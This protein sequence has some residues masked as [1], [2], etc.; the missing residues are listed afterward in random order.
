MSLLSLDDETNMIIP[1]STDAPVYHFPFAT[2]GL[3]VVNVICFLISGMGSMEHVEQWASFSLQHGQGLHPVQWVT[4]NFLHAG[5]MHLAGNMIFFWGFGLVVEGKL[6]WWKMLVVYLGIGMT[7]CAIEQVLMLGADPMAALQPMIAAANEAM[8]EGN[9]PPDQVIEL[10]D[11]I[12]ELR[13]GTSLDRLPGSLGAS[14]IIY[15]MLAMSLVWAPKNEVNCLF[16]AGVRSFTFEI[17]IMTFALWYIG[18]EILMTTLQGFS[19]TTPLLHLMGAGV[20]FAAGVALLKAQ[21]VDCED[22]DLFAV[23][24]GH[25]G[26]FAR[27]SYGNRIERPG[28][29]K[30][31][32]LTERKKTPAKKAGPNLS[33]RKKALDQIAALIESGNFDEANDELYNLRIKDSEAVL[34]EEL[35]SRLAVGLA[36]NGQ[37]DPAIELMHEFIDL[38]PESADVMRLR[39]AQVHLNGSGDAHAALRTLREIN[40]ELLAEEKRPLLKK[41]MKQAKESLKDE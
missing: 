34:E 6:G 7:Q 4:S 41:L 21:M 12:Q 35:L 37:Y 38:Y 22:W 2:I 27:D 15:G 26:P 29:A 24:S 36:K 8:A 19:M 5:F 17:T 30:S 31:V 14:S 16:F 11:A 40:A 9:L 3:I 1:L 25:Y 20:G 39:L 32:E 33:V 28:A 13:A 10:R 18:E 23:M